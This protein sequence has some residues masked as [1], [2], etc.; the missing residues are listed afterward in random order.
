L[1]FE[2]ARSGE[3]LNQNNQ[4]EKRH[5]AKSP[6]SLQAACL[7]AQQSNGWLLLGSVAQVKFCKAKIKTAL[8]TEIPHPI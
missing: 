4:S 2:G 8:M 3:K 1:N 6:V 7:H 5:H